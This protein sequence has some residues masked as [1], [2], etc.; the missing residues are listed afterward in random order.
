MLITKVLLKLLIPVRW[1]SSVYFNFHY[2]PF[3]QA[4]KLPIHLRK[5]HFLMLKGKI[6]I[7]CPAKQIKRGMIQLGADCDIARLDAGIRIRIEGGSIIFKGKCR[8][9][10]DSCLHIGEKGNLIF[11]NNFV[12]STKVIIDC[13][14]RIEFK[15]NVR[16]GPGTLI[17]DTDFHAMQK[18]A[19]NSGGDAPKR[20]AM[21]QSQSVKTAGLPP[22]A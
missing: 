21:A 16:V 15:E 8:I 14:H 13:Y 22:A 17:M 18:V 4:V 3:K 5:P 7:D 12:N 20:K 19:A 1:A 11:A 6:I 10:T 2:L 9:G